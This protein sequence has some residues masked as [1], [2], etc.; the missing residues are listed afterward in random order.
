[1]SPHEQLVC[2]KQIL[3]GEYFAPTSENQAIEK[4]LESIGSLVP[5]RF[6]SLTLRKRFASDQGTRLLK[7]L[8]WLIDGESAEK[9]HGDALSRLVEALGCTA[10]TTHSG[11]RSKAPQ[12]VA[13]GKWCAEMPH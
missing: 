4:A 11:I 9:P 3:S 7:D 13:N 5:F 1:M 10:Q 12:R 2:A 6:V 8:K